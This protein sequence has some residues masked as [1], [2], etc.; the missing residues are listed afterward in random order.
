MTLHYI[1]LLGAGLVL[2]WLVLLVGRWPSLGWA[3]VAAFVILADALPQTPSIVSVGGLTVYPED[4]AT[5]VFGTVA[6]HRAGKLRSA[7]A[8]LDL[9]VAVTALLLVSLL[10]GVATIGTGPAVNE[11]RQTALLVVLGAWILS[12]VGD[13]SL[14]KT[15]QRFVMWTAW[16]LTGVA[17]WHVM[18]RGLGNADL[19]VL[20]A[21]NMLVTTRPLVSGQ[22]AFV[23]TAA[24]AAIVEGERRRKKFFAGQAAVFLAVVAVCQHRSV[25]LAA[26]AGLLM[27]ILVGDTR[28]RVKLLA[29]SV[30][31]FVGTMMLYLAGTLNGVL[32]AAEIAVTSTGTYGDRLFG[33]TSLINSSFASGP[34]TV[35]AGRPFGS[36]VARISGTGILETFA[37][38]N[39]YVTLYL[40]IGLVGILLV[41]LLI[42][43]SL[44]R[45]VRERRMLLAAWLMTTIVFAWPYNLPWYFGVFLILPM[46]HWQRVAEQQQESGA[47]SL[48]FLTGQSAGTR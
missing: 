5:L 2:A 4:V 46:V 43:G 35:I 1:E 21:Q 47:V 36:G 18:T 39:W 40:R 19:R 8:G 14:E 38:H 45:C 28:V 20:N 12:Q 7:L 24:L 31:A 10:W 6:V 33:W 11:F 42:F 26:I 22:A 15:V 3:L 16:V 25:W 13:A 32:H 48:T 17:A 30:I 29:G 27:L 34:L 37:T 9:A 44:V 23:A 41:V